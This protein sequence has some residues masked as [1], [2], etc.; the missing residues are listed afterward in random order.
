M[1]NPAGTAGAHG[2]KGVSAGHS[3]FAPRLGGGFS[4][5]TFRCY[6]W[7]MLPDH[8]LLRRS[9]FTTSLI[10]WTLRRS[11]GLG[12]A[13][14]FA[15]L[16]YLLRGFRLILGYHSFE[17]LSVSPFVTGGGAGDNKPEN[18]NLR[19]LSLKAG[20]NSVLGARKLY[21][22]EHGEERRERGRLSTTMRLTDIGKLVDDPA[23]IIDRSLSSKLHIRSVVACHIPA[24]QWAV[25]IPVQHCGP[26]DDTKLLERD[27]RC[28][29]NY[30]GPPPMHETHSWH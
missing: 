29:L 25:E 18:P 2:R 13:T 9:R 12:F 15:F 6:T 8:S 7:A 11:W 26:I 27:V 4:I 1:R 10:Q 23:P 17:R 24:M 22:G 20:G 3:S 21:T 19:P 14:S 30:S 5:A 28:C 16:L